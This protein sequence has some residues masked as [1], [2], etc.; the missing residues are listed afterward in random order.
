MNVSEMNK[1]FFP[2]LADCV[3]TV[4][5]FVWTMVMITV[6]EPGRVSVFY[7]LIDLLSNP[8]Q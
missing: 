4:L 2:T 1:L 3:R 5:F 8:Q 7:E 6:V